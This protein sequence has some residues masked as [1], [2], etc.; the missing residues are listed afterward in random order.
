MIEMCGGAS[1]ASLQNHESPSAT[2]MQH[3]H[4]SIFS[5]FS[6]FLSFPSFPRAC[7]LMPSRQIQELIHPFHSMS[8]LKDTPRWEQPNKQNTNMLQRPVSQFFSE[9]WPLPHQLTWRILHQQSKLSTTEERSRFYPTYKSK[10]TRV[11][12][13]ER[14]YIRSNDTWDWEGEDKERLKY[15]T[16]FF[17]TSLTI[18]VFTRASIVKVMAPVPIASSLN[19]IAV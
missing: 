12:K 4:K 14:P 17:L 16:S 8:S 2:H 10:K 7:L 9:T 6:S 1:G 18:R 15:N 3:Q 5:N 11:Y 13:R 19:I